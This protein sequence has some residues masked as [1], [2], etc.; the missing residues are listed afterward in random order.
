MRR[1]KQIQFMGHLIP[2]DF[3]ARD[4]AKEGVIAERVNRVFNDFDVLITPTVASQPIEVGRF[5]GRG[6][7]A[8]MFTG[9]RGFG[10]AFTGT[11]NVCGNPAASVP[12]GIGE[13]AC[14][15]RGADDR[16]SRRRG[17]ACL[18]RSPGRGREAWAQLHP[19]VS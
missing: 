18:A 3:L 14:R 4:R 16:P 11:W 7:L 5:E 13:G 19:A 6:A 2:D 15:W 12:A 9:L 10:A 17:N 1:T 8:T